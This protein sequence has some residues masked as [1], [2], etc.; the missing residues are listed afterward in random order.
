MG[1]LDPQGGEQAGGGV[2]HIVERVRPL[3]FSPRL[4]AAIAAMM[5]GTPALSNLVDF[6]TSRLSNRM[7]KRPCP[8]NPEQ[9]SSS[10]Q[11]I[12]ALRPMTRSS[13][14]DEGSPNVSYSIRIP[15]ARAQGMAS[16]PPLVQ[17]SASPPEMNVRK[18]Q[19]QAA[20]Q[21]ES[22]YPGASLLRLRLQ[23]PHSRFAESLRHPCP[24]EELSPRAVGDY[25]C[26][27]S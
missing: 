23:Q 13:G 1:L 18:K 19:V 2:R 10:Q 21:T 4:I 9:N 27:M 15:F 11:I 17:V 12:C 7:T 14:G 20:H 25:L 16:P 8:T 3:T 5:S 6:P 22:P 26:L 24:Q